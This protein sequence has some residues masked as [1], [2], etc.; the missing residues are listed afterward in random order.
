MVVFYNG[1][2]DDSPDKTY[3]LIDVKANGECWGELTIYFAP[4]DTN[5]DEIRHLTMSDDQT[6]LSF[7]VFHQS[8]YGPITLTLTRQN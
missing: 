7:D 4:G 5:I 2:N 3:D 6:H 8:I 1:I